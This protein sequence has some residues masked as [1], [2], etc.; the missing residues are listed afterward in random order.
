MRHSPTDLSER[1]SIV[2][3]ASRG[4]GRGV[5]VAFARAGAPV[6]AVARSSEALTDLAAETPGVRAEVVD[7]GDP[8]AAGALID[9]YHPDNVIIVAGATPLIRPLQQHT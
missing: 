5:A 1:T 9:R 4:L 7:A 3:G 2:V 6:I 8:T